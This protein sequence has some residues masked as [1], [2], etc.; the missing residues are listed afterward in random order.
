VF[1]LGNHPTAEEV[2]D[3]VRKSIPGISLSTVYRNLGVLLEQGAIQ[4]VS[5]PGNELRYDHMHHDHCH[6]HCISCG[7]VFDVDMPPSDLEELLPG[8]AHGFRIESVYIY[9]TGVCP[10]CQAGSRGKEEG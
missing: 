3:A 7:G 6:L 9:F 5:G 2:F 4:A 10:V 8:P 1:L